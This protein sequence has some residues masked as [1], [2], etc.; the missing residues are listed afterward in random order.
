VREQPFHKTIFLD[1]FIRLTYQEVIGEKLIDKKINYDSS[2]QII[3]DIANAPNATEANA[4]LI[5]GVKDVNNFSLN[6]K[7]TAEILFTIDGFIKSE[8]LN[9]QDIKMI[10]RFMNMKILFNKIEKEFKRRE[11]TLY[12]SGYDAMD[13]CLLLRKDYSYTNPLSPNEIKY[14]SDYK[15]PDGCFKI[16]A[17]NKQIKIKKI[18]KLIY[19][20]RKLMELKC[21]IN[22]SKLSE[23]TILSDYYRQLLEGLSEIAERKQKITRLLE[24]IVCRI[25]IN[26]SKYFKE[27]LEDFNYFMFAH[28]K[29]H[30]EVNEDGTIIERP[31]FLKEAFYLYIEK[32]NS[33]SYKLV[34]WPMF[35][36]NTLIDI[37][38]K[39]LSSKRNRQLVNKCIKC[40]QF[41]ISHKADKRNKYCSKCS[42]LSHMTKEQRAQYMREVYRPKKKRERE[43]QKEKAYIQRLL[44][45]GFSER[46]AEELWMGDNRM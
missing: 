17:D 39:Y 31:I 36:K 43:A 25:N 37:T 11:G 3:V 33:G 13:E 44:K 8:K 27:F 14:N 7:E 29:T 10:K 22:E 15:I 16:K 30:T 12:L 26:D 24:E 6:F 40:G 18:R 35:Y 42:R 20:G 19:L 41:Y 1:H 32:N 5:E 23:M 21:H 9:K 45:A 38:I 28:K 2:G 4:R 46:E 34:G